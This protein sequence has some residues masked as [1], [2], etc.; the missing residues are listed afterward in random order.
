MR[1]KSTNKI[2]G[3]G[4]IRVPDGVQLEK[5]AKRTAEWGRLFSK[6]FFCTTAVRCGEGMG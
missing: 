4:A 6:R 2:R 5:K 3:D 1:T